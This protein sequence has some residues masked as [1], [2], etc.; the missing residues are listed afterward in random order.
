MAI[1]RLNLNLTKSQMADINFNWHLECC[2]MSANIENELM[3]C[4]E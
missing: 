1:S 3:Q 4:G 2:N